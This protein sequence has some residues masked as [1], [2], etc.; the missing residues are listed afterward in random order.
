MQVS[1]G[2]AQPLGATDDGRGTNFSVYSSVAEKV[3]VCLFDD[4][5]AERRVAL[6]GRTGD[7][8]HG[9]LTGIG[10][11]Q[12]YGYRVHG[13]WSPASGHL[14][15]LEKLLLDPY[16][17]AVAGEVQWDDALF[18]FDA[19]HP[20]APANRNDTGA[21]MPKSVVV[22][23]H[24]DWQEDRRPATR[25][26]DTIIYEVHVKGFTN[27][28][29][30]IPSELR[31]TYAGLAHPD[32]I[33]HLTRL[34]VT[35]VELL[36]VQEF[37]HRRRLVAHGLH[38]YW[39][40]DPVCPFAPHHAYASHRGA[41]GAVHE[42]KAMVRDLHRAGLEVILDVVF[43][44]T[45]EGGVDGPVLSFKGLDNRAYYRLEAGE[46]LR[47]TDFTGT[48]N[49][50]HTEHPQVQ[51]MIVD[52]LRYWVTEMH[53]DGF[54]F[55]L[56]PVL[57]RVGGGVDFEGGIFSAIARDPALSRV[58]LIAEPWDLGP[59][60]YQVGRFPG[61][62]SEWNDKFR[63]DVRDFWN[64]RDGSAR[65]LMLR[66]AGSP[67]LYQAAGRRPLASVNFVTCHDG[68]TLRDLV[69]YERKHNEANRGDEQS[70]HDD[71]HAWN[72]GAE[73]PTDD[74]AVN[75][76]RARQ[77]RNFIATALLAR[78]VPMLLGGDELGRTQGG[79]NNAYCLDDEMAWFDWEKADHGLMAFVSALS[80]MRRAHAAF[81]RNDWPGR[82]GGAAG[83]AGMTWYDAGGREVHESDV[84]ND[85]RPPL[86]VF[87]S[88]QHDF[89]VLFNPGAGETRFALP[90]PCRHGAWRVL[91][92]TALD[93]PP[94]GGGARV[95]K[96]LTLAA[97]TLVALTRLP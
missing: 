77:Q 35:A 93:T 92:D 47:Y 20:E 85:A 57:G 3:E 15:C 50:L 71:N 17:R 68:F 11:G 42:F 7:C 91:V 40:Y 44:H 43:N 1:Q 55:D 78:G 37:I 32:A 82:S 84:T 48:Q 29:P 46:G 22:D 19:D 13:P 88:D 23:T 75:A 97:H 63:D 54:R 27:R 34:G 2:H 61:G 31:G 66:F 58:K 76:V 24:F 14:C 64:G 89:L 79:N 95:Q 86:Q 36:P 18:P 21:H 26:E 90:P 6:P 69:S 60:G 59:D 8:W 70:G 45:G 87:L 25:I 16:G 51:R 80:A 4:G 56:A 10:P 74:A 38:N 49:T 96:S 33:A 39:G 83:T 12:R 9:Y 73:G 5:G 67:D 53:V 65:R 94:D 41:G 30:A 81:R 28:H 62:W 52:A 72:C